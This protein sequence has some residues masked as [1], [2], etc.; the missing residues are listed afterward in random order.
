VDEIARTQLL[1]QETDRHLGDCQR[2]ERVH[3]TQ[4]AAAACASFPS[5]VTSK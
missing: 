4:G 5:N 2:V 3:P 1:S